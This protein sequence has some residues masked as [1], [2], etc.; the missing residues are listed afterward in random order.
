MNRREFLQTASL[1]AAAVATGALHRPLH[2][3]Q[4]EQVISDFEKRLWPV[5]R[6][7]DVK[8]THVWG[9]SPVD[10]PDGKVHLFFANWKGG[11]GGWITKCRVGHAVSEKPE[12]PFEVL[13]DAVL[14][15]RGGDH[16][17]ASTIHNPTIH[18]VGDRYALFYIGSSTAIAK[19]QKLHIASTQ[20]IGLAMADKIDGPFRRVGEGPIFDVNP[21]K[22]AWDDYIVVNPALLKHPNGQFWLYYKAWDQHQEFPESQRRKRRKG[23][24]KLGLAVADRI[25]GP[26]RRHPQNPIVDF[27][28]LGQVWLEDPYV[29]MEGDKFYMIA[30]DMYYYNTQVGLLFESDDGVHWSKPKV[31]YKRASEY[32]GHDVLRYKNERFERPQVLVRDGHPAYLYCAFGN[33]R[34]YSTG[35]VFKVRPKSEIK[36]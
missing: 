21:E 6:V 31:G 14:K 27:H 15:G 2:E 32:F 18:K 26:Y 33:R 29:F 7:L 19:K 30:R 3:S 25:E 12:G 11:H 36:S 28:R 16:W 24:R 17:D 35:V 5:G 10:G 9:C 13:D 20:R 22:P 8:D 23:L 34:N 1:G 4:R